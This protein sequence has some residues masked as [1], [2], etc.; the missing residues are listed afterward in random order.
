MVTIDIVL[1]IGDCEKQMPMDEARNLYHELG[2]LFNG[3]H[4]HE[5]NRVPQPSPARPATREPVQAQP[6]ERSTEM[7]PKVAEARSKAST[8]GCGCNKKKPA[9]QTKTTEKDK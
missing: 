5:M 1:K 7:H 9:A 4:V 8:G 3:S 6:Q 2:R